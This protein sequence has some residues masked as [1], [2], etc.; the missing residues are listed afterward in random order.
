[1]PTINIKCE[2]GQ[3]VE[4]DFPHGPVVYGRVLQVRPVISYKD[5]RVLYVIDGYT[6]V[7]KSCQ[8]TVEEENV[9][10]VHVT[11]VALL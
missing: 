8:F 5:T 11:K 9:M 1:M 6:S 4:V 10:G 7:G 3:K 2:P